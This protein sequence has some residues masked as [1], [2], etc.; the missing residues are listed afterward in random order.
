MKVHML[1]KIYWA[2]GDDTNTEFVANC[3]FLSVGHSPKGIAENDKK[4]TCLRCL[5][6]MKSKPGRKGKL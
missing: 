4:V 3:G 5:S 6:K 2:Y 1:K